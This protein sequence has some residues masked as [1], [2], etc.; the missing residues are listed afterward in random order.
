MVSIMLPFKKHFRKEENKMKDFLNYD[1]YIG[2]QVICHCTSHDKEYFKV[3]KIIGTANDREYLVETTDDNGVRVVITRLS[4]HLILIH[5]RYIPFVVNN[6]FYSQCEIK[7]LPSVSSL[8]EAHQSLD[9]ASMDYDEDY[10]L[11][12]AAVYKEFND[13]GENVVFDYID[14][15]DR[16]EVM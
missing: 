10:F 2:D 11:T 9:D 7:V 13:D 4:S 1:L 12:N 6:N 16:K 14:L 8:E 15:N 3:G 5:K